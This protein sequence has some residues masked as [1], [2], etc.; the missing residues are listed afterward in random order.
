[1]KTAL[2][3]GGTGPTGHYIVNGL[4]ARGFTVSILHT[5]QHEVDEIPATVTHIHTNPFNEN[6]MLEALGNAQFDLTVAMYGRL[7]RIAALMVGRTERFMSVGGGPAYRGYMN[8]TMYDPPGLPVPTPETA[9]KAVTEAED[10]KGYRVYRTEEVVFRHHP[11]A[12]HFRYPQIYGAYQITPREWPI[13]RRIL[14]KRPFI[15]LPDDGLTLNHSGAAENMAHALLLAVDRP[16]VASGQVYNC[17]DDHVLTLKQVVQLCAQAL[18]HEW[19]IISMPYELA[20]SA[21]PLISQPWTTH[22][23]FD[24][25]KIKAE[26]GY[27]DIV[28]PIEAVQQAAVWL[29]QHPLERGSKSERLLHDPFDYAAEDRLV[30][31][32]QQALAAMPKELFSREPGYTIAYS[33][34]GGSSRKS[35]W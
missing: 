20:V 14:D 34:P 1:M 32:W 19:E 15:I 27:H 33:G 9:P 17:G 10:G 13:V 23:V 25:S 12:T 35:D 31:A 22:R 5:G 29:S 21:R 4:I 24:L 7:R 3:I 30:T 6:A 28:S 11:T 18:H 16:Q 26:L 8:A 2:V